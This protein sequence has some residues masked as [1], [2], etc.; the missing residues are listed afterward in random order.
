[1]KFLLKVLHSYNT[2]TLA[3]T[4]RHD[5]KVIQLWNEFI[6]LKV[7]YKNRKTLS[8]QICGQNGRVCE[9]ISKNVHTRFFLFSVK[10]N[11]KDSRSI[12]KLAKQFDR[13]GV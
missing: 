3:P 7:T 11:P 8:A 2:G 5:K 1:M 13:H 9:K 4:I 10:S 6:S 12:I